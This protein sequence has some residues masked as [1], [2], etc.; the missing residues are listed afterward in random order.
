MDNN[1]IYEIDNYLNQIIANAE[2]I[3]DNKEVSEYASKIKDAA[4]SIEALIT[5]TCI[6]KTKIKVNGYSTDFANI[7]G[8]KV[9]IVDDVIENIEIMRNIFTT[10]SCKIVSACSGEEALEIFSNGFMPDIVCMDIVMPGI[11]GATTTKELKSMGCEAYFIAISALKNQSKNIVS[12]FDYWLTKPFTLE[13]ITAALSAY[14]HSDE[15]PNETIYKLDSEI[16]TQKK[17]ELLRLAQEGAYSKLKKLIASLENS[18]SKE[19][20]NK[21]LKRIDLNSIIKSIVSP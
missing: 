8:L 9:M 5:D 6:K 16:P 3:E 18:K 17:D 4:Y 10:F 11:D 12:I 1:I 21:S 14:K 15:M 19:F 20:L 7:I 13:H 2:H